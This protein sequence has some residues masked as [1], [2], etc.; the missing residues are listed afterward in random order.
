MTR[1]LQRDN[2]GPYLLFQ[3]AVMLPKNPCLSMNLPPDCVSAVSSSMRS[4]FMFQAECGHVL[5]HSPQ[6]DVGI[7]VSVLSDILHLC[8]YLYRISSWNKEA[9]ERQSLLMF[10]VP[11]VYTFL[12]VIKHCYL[13]LARN[14]KNWRC[15]AY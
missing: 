7:S 3:C 11:L 1:S 2:V 14:D 15:L 10:T 8:A 12:S 13:C 6:R 4:R 9:P 5:E